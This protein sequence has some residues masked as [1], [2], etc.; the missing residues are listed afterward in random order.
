M[1]V[2]FSMIIM[3]DNDYTNHMVVLT[4]IVGNLATM[5]VVPNSLIVLLSFVLWWWWLHC[6]LY[7]HFSH[8]VRPKT[9]IIM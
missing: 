7:W 3:S 9:I 4:L 6:N 1:F 8:K 2:R 5:S